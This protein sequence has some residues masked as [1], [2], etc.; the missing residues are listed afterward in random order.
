MTVLNDVL[1][2]K[3]NVLGSTGKRK[4][5]K[6]RSRFFCRGTRPR[7]TYGGISSRWLHRWRIA[8]HQIS[9]GSANR[10]NQTSSIFLPIMFGTSMPSSLMLESRQHSS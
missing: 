3:L 5:P 1:L 10:E 4:I 7:H 6:H 9:S 2:S 8:S